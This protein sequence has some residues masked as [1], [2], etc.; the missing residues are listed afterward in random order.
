MTPSND[1]PRWAVKA[2]VWGLTGIIAIVGVW[3]SGIPSLANRV[4]AI[5][6]IQKELRAEIR[7]GFR[8]LTQRIDQLMSDRK[9]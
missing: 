2:L 7:E 5:E 4:T 8:T 6:E 9:R 3:I 1:L